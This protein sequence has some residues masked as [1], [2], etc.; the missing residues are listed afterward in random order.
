MTGPMLQPTQRWWD[1]DGEGEGPSAPPA[2]SSPACVSLPE[3]AEVLRAFGDGFPSDTRD[4][5]LDSVSEVDDS[6]DGGVTDHAAV[7][8]PWRPI[9]IVAGVVL[10]LCLLAGGGFAGWRA[11]S[12]HR[13]R[14]AHA[15]CVEAVRG[16]DDAWRVLQDAIADESEAFAVDDSQV[17]DPTV[18]S[19]LAS[20]VDGLPDSPPGGSCPA[21]A[22]LTVLE[23]TASAARGREDSYRDLARRVHDAAD[24]VIASRD[25]K[26][27]ADAAA[28]L[29]DTVD[30]ADAL[31]A[32]SDGRVQD[33]AT[34]ETLQRAIDQAGTLLD[35]GDD[36]Q[37][38]RDAVAALEQAMT[39]VD[40]SIRAKRD[41]DARAAAEDAAVAQSGM[42]GGSA[43][44]GGSSV[45]GSS[46][47]YRPSDGYSGGSSPSGSVGGWD[48]PS[49][50]TPV[51]GGTDPSL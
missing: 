41:A 50:D 16:R 18:V 4:R 51:F 35:A 12:D 36:A 33:D 40:D 38:M 26:T 20:L 2:V 37:A 34:R 15:S 3:R 32:D 28:A 23:S 46:G 8:V 44:D 42:S 9:L 29:K 48:V 43:A 21:D 47:G 7:P 11:W 24:E 49:P 25:A 17:A 30:R 22:S 14:E 39:G 45:S 1:D 6:D 10:A 5:Y 27:L 13:V 31:L 19:A